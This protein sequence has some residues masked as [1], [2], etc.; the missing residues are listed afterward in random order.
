MSSM[1]MVNTLAKD[2]IVDGGS[3]ETY[4]FS[5]DDSVFITPMS[6]NVW[7]YKYYWTDKDSLYFRSYDGIMEPAIYFEFLDSNSAIFGAYR[8]DDS[9][10]FYG[11]F[12]RVK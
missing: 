11:L 2:T 9:L 3:N 12:D 6:N 4:I 5:P 7:V 10:I 1:R 8:G